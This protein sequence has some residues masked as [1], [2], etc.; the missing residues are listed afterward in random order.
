MYNLFNG[1]L[2]R[3]VAFNIDGWEEKSS[4][5][6]E[7]FSTIFLNPTEAS[8]LYGGWDNEFVT[9]AELDGKPAT[10]YSWLTQ[11]PESIMFSIVRA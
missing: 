6:L 8:D 1:K 2:K 5:N 3:E 7:E 4:E 9:N 10:V 11:L